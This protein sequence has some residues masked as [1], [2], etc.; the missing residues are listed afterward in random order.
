MWSA[1]V[2]ELN[3]SWGIHAV[4]YHSH[5]GDGM[6]WDANGAKMMMRQHHKFHSN[7]FK[8][9]AMQN[10]SGNYFVCEFNEFGSEK[11]CF[12]LFSS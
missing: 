5:E 3:T 10:P 4:T 11:E 9:D 1:A 12:E 2:S 7:S 8:R 6:Q